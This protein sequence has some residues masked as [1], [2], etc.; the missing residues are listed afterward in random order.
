MEDQVH[1]AVMARMRVP[2]EA[3][4]CAR[5]GAR[6]GGPGFGGWRGHSVSHVVREGRDRGQQRDPAGVVHAGVTTE[7][8]W[9]ASGFQ[10]SFPG[11]T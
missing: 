6:V 4:R 8:D 2:W 11:R 3:R 10:R 1:V 5:R 7:G 9:A